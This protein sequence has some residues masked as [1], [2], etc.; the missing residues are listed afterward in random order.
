MFSPLFLYFSIFLPFPPFSY[1]VS[2]LCAKKWQ[3]SPAVG[4]LEGSVSFPIHCGLGRSPI[5][6]AAY[7]SRYKKMC[8]AVAIF[9]LF[10]GT[11][12]SIY[13]SF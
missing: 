13:K 5:A 2:P 7:I 1:L 9:V 6:K 3:P 8:L 12:T 10:V 4:G 11:K